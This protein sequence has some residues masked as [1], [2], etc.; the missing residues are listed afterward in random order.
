MATIRPHQVGQCPHCLTTV[1]F[2]GHSLNYKG[3][4]KLLENAE[5]LQFLTVAV[6]PECNHSTITVEVGS[7][8]EYNRDAR[9]WATDEKISSWRNLNVEKEIILW[10][11][12]R[13][14]S[15]PEGV[16]AHIAG[17]YKEAMAVL[18]ISP[19]ASAALSRRCLQALLKDA[20]NA[21]QDNL[22]KQIE[23]A[24]KNLPPYLA[25]NIDAIRN[26][27][28]FAAHPTKAEDSG[29]IVE[30]EPGEAEWNLEVIEMLFD[31]YYVQLPKNEKMR[32]ALNAKLK[33]AGK[34]PMK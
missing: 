28:N 1:K 27:G 25:Q 31:F 34:K 12:S 33:S 26:I 13:V 21:A 7:W 15:V 16:P 17:D 30:V 8:G 24:Q 5:R 18:D 23:T 22:A 14:A 11:R 2:G 10:P 4:L 20:G 6:C 19:K 3:T 29:Q 9:E 32:D